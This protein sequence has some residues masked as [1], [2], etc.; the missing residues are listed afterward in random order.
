MLI[1]KIFNQHLDVQKKT[2]EILEKK[3]YSASEMVSNCL[4]NNGLVMWCGNGGSASDSMHLSAELLGRSKKK[5]RSL[6]SISLAAD[7]SLITCISNDFGYEN[8][9]SRQLEG[10]ANKNDVFISLTTSGNSVNIISAIRKA[11]ELNLKTILMSGNSGG[12]CAGLTDLELL[13]PST[14]T[15]RIQEMH[16]LIGHSLCDLIEEHLNLN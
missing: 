10:L 5:R 1:K 7:S 4:K 15:A 14:S 6:R 11:K 13:V 2:L 9:F 3:I 8:L 16:M 12:K